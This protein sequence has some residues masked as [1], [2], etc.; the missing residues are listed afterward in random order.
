MPDE[1]LAPFDRPSSETFN[2]DFLVQLRF[3]HQRKQG[4]TGVR[5]RFTVPKTDDN[6]VV[7]QKLL[8]EFNRVI[9]TLEEKGACTALGR[10][11]RLNPGR[12]PHEDPPALSGNAANAKEVAAAR[13]GKV[14]MTI[15]PAFNVLTFFAGYR[16]FKTA[17]MHSQNIILQRIMLWLELAISTHYD[18]WL[19][20]SRPDLHGDLHSLITKSC[21]SMVGVL[22]I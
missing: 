4:K 18:Q 1:H 20:I 8:N 14:K 16:L 3:L 7:G 17:S 13:A 19:P 9:R 5:R 12:T 2:F 22:L 15:H 10:K 21:L 6:Q 11:V